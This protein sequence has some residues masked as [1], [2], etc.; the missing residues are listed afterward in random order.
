M[1]D[2]TLSGTHEHVHLSVR[3]ATAT[4]TGAATLTAT[5]AA[6]AT[7]TDLPTIPTKN[8]SRDW[9]PGTYQNVPRH[10]HSRT[11]GAQGPDFAS[12]AHITNTTF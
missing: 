7:G 2:K 3:Q 1:R 6:T 4:A 5:A 11:K 8:L 12:I 10:V 9:A